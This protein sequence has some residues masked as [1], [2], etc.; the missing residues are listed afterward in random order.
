MTKK[1]ESVENRILAA[2]TL[3]YLIEANASLQRVAA[4]SNHLIPSMAS[5]V[6]WKPQ[7]ENES[8]ESGENNNRIDRLLG[9][10]E[11]KENNTNSTSSGTTSKDMQRAAFRVFAA[12]GANDEDIRKRII[13]TENLMPSLVKALEEEHDPTLQMAAI[14]CLHSLSRSV[15]LLRTTFQV[16]ILKLKSK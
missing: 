5:F 1:E 7:N 12:L 16:S 11:F 6:N 8:L 15:Q 14:G 4:I 2:E 3:A 13:E 10:S 9:I